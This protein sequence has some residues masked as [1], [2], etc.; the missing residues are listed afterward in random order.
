MDGMEAT[1]VAPDGG[2]AAGGERSRE[3]LLRLFAG[4][5]PDKFLADYRARNGGER[6]RFN[7]VWP[8]FFFG[9][10]WF[11]HR[12]MF[13]IGVLMLLIPLALALLFPTLADK[14]SIGLGV[15]LAFMG[16]PAYV[17]FAQRKITAIEASGLPVE[18]RDRLIREA[19]GVSWIGS[20]VGGLLL[21]ALLVVAFS[22]SLLN[23]ELPG[24]DSKV[25]SEVTNRAVLSNL[26]AKN[27]PTEG[28]SVGRF[29]EVWNSDDKADPMRRCSFE[30]RAPDEKTTLH[31]LVSWKDQA[32]GEF[33]V[34]V[35]APG[36]P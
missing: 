24:C 21:F 20:S 18:E 12:K 7:V 30:L 16:P 14:G 27:L 23:P 1:A 19:G 2:L 22:P 33:Q 31:L 28:V 15:A 3:D 17:W 35:T 11:F 25:V 26:T 4:P 34:R 32:K 9:F 5:N 13:G 36:S 6:K 29:A 10:V 8:A